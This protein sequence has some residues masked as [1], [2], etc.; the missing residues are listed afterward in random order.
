MPARTAQDAWIEQVLGL[1]RA[2]GPGSFGA[3]QQDRPLDAGPPSLMLDYEDESLPMEDRIQACATT[4]EVQRAAAGI[5]LAAR[6]AEPVLTKAIAG[7]TERLGGRMIGLDYKI[8]GFHSLARKIA[9]DV[10]KTGI[11][12]EEAAGGICDAVRYTSCFEPEDYTEGVKA[13]L[14]D[15]VGNGNT[16]RKLK[17][18]WVKDIPYKGINVQLTDPNK[19]VFELQFHTPRG[20]KAKDEDTHHIYEEM[21]LLNSTSARWKELDRQQREIFKDVPVPD[22]VA[23]IEEV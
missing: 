9:T 5:L 2:D 22:G 12:A 3:L 8:K 11:S 23:T 19:Q 15:L 13:V 17:N 18:A 20:F 4:R 16:I 14:E 21:R 1:R 10:V 7:T 6:K